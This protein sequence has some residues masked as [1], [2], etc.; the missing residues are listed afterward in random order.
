MNARQETA[1]GVGVADASDSSPGVEEAAEL[2]VT[3]V[4]L[5]R[6]LRARSDTSL[7]P[8]QT[9]VL[10]RVE[11]SGPLRMGA[12]A[13]A[14]GTSPATVCRLIDTLAQ[15][16]LIERVPDP[17]DGR[18]SLVQASPEGASLVGAL[19]ARGTAALRS[20]LDDL[21]VEERSVIRQALPALQALT[22][23]LQGGSA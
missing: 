2:R 3:L 1:G 14:E 17:L 10:A 18:A 13:K 16:G 8:S 20:A 4:R 22:E 9:S 21:S 23:R 12:L 7:T 6:Q 19:R 15:D 11:E 5:Q